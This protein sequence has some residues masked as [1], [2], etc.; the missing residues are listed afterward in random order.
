MEIA[1]Q[2]PRASSRVVHRDL[3]ADLKV[4]VEGVQQMVGLFEV[5]RK[6]GVVGERLDPPPEIDLRNEAQVI[7]WILT[8]GNL[9][10]VFHWALTCRAGL[11]A[12]VAD[13]QFRVRAPDAEEGVVHNLRVGSAAAL[14][15]ISESNPHLT[16]SAFSAALAESLVREQA[17]RHGVE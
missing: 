15:E 8:S 14:T 11:N 2:D 4:L 3:N 10:T 7:E 13:E 5:L 16:I 12:L 6:Y 1:S 17:K 9:N